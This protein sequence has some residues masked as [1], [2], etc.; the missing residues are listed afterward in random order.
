MPTMKKENVTI[1]FESEQLAALEF[2]LKKRTPA[3]RRSWKNCSNV[4]MNPRCR[5]RYGNIS[6]AA[7]RPLSVPAV[8]QD[9]RSRSRGRSLPPRWHSLSAKGLVTEMADHVDIT[10]W[11][12]RRWKDA[13]EKHLRDET[14]EEH[15]EDVLDEL[16]NQLP[17]REYKRISAEIYAEDAA[18]RTE[19]EAARTYAAYHVTERGQEWYFKTSPGEEL[20][21][22]AEKLRGYATAEK[23]TV[24][25]LFIKMFADGRPITAE[26]YN[27][28]TAV[29]MEN[30]GKVRGVFDMNFDKREFSAVHIMDGW[31]TWVMRDVSAAVYHATR[32]QFASSDDKWRK[33]LDHLSGKEITSAG[34]LSARNFSFGDEIIESD[35][36]LNFYVQAEFDIDAAFGTFVLTDKND[37]W[38]NIYANYDI[39]ED[40]PCDTLELTLCK[41]D[42]SEESWSYQ[43]N[44]AEQDVL[45]RK[46]EEYCQ[47]QTGMSLHDYAQQF[48]EEP[49]QQQGPV[50]KL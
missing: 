25:D 7:Q 43:L 1:T 21:N 9:R 38:L 17:E 31:K 27:A 29:R 4:S 41:G 45:L 47:K 42:G 26:E 34:H 44:A 24:P 30:T 16:C 28:L 12:D 22:A 10:L 49:E 14:L 33:L 40:R 35:G 50:M 2:S 15:L 6:P 19:E 37:D 39:A 5:S 36:K 32:S 18:R 3:C 46:M 11:I 8:R 48:R 20:L 23:G 13:I